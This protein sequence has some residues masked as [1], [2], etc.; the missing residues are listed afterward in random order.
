MAVWGGHTSSLDLL[1]M[2]GRPQ[3]SSDWGLAV[4][5][6]YCAGGAVDGSVA[7]QGVHGRDICRRLTRRTTR[8]AS[9]AQTA[10]ST[11]PSVATLAPNAWS[12]TSGTSAARSSEGPP[13]PDLG[14]DPD[15]PPG[16]HQ[17]MARDTT[18]V[19]E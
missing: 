8:M 5:H 2:L 12:L 15:E 6:S 19:W 3:L 17:A 11:T 9:T 13:G 10:I 1:Q 16:Q 14:G 4:G 18:Q 7:H